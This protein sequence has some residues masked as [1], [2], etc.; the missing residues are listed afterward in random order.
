MTLGSILPGL[1]AAK[2]GRSF[3]A[4]THQRIHRPAQSIPRLA[5]CDLL[6]ATTLANSLHGT[7]IAPSQIMAGGPRCANRKAIALKKAK[8]SKVKREFSRYCPTL[9]F[10]PSNQANLNRSSATNS[11]SLLNLH[12]AHSLP[13]VC[14]GQSIIES[15]RLHHSHF[16]EGL[17]EWYDAKSN[18]HW[19]AEQCHVN[20]TGRGICSPTA[21]FKRDNFTAVTSGG[22]ICKKFE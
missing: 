16:Q 18:F 6:T 4:G 3:E 9:S 8:C 20:S 22:G 10:V 13:T 1:S 21:R 14:R 7:H 12:D 5:S 2:F 15:I 17:R 19:I 11:K